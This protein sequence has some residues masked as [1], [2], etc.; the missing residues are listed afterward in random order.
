MW[1]TIPLCLWLYWLEN[2]QNNL[3][4]H[5]MS[6]SKHYMIYGGSKGGRSRATVEFRILQNLIE[7]VK[8]GLFYC[9][10]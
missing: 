5:G 4:L 10:Q 7:T 3:T 2:E 8:R 6:E 1:V 9:L